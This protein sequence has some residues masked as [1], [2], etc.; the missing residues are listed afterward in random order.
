MACW[1]HEGEILGFVGLRRLPAADYTLRVCLATRNSQD[2]RLPSEEFSAQSI[3]MCG[4]DIDPTVYFSHGLSPG[5]DALLSLNSGGR[6]K[7]ARRHGILGQEEPS[8]VGRGKPRVAGTIII[9][10]TKYSSDD[11]LYR[12]CGVWVWLALISASNHRVPTAAADNEEMRLSQGQP[13]TALKSRLATEQRRNPP[14]CLLEKTRCRPEKTVSSLGAS[15]SWRSNTVTSKA[16]TDERFR[17]ST[18]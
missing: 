15:F 13:E 8:M 10:A 18:L 9:A 14:A 5:L 12:Y 11:R 3:G 17:R 1:E 4:L 16:R 6:K 7:V 2:V